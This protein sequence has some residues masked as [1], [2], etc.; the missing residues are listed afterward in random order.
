[1][2]SHYWLCNLCTKVIAGGPE[3][4]GHF[5]KAFRDLGPRRRGFWKVAAQQVADLAGNPLEPE[6]A[7]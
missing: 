4:A 1:M 6:D 3:P 7:A 2:A 5:C